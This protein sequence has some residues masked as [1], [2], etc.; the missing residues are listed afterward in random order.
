MVGWP[1]VS[2]FAAI[3]FAVLS[4]VAEPFRRIAMRTGAV[5][6]TLICAGFL[7]GPPFE[8]IAGGLVLAL[9]VWLGILVIRSGI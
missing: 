6:S 2:A 8:L 5:A 3:V 7:A 9:L 4:V 1:A